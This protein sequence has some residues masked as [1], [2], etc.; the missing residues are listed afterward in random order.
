MV[1]EVLLEPSTFEVVLAAC[2]FA[3]VT[4]PA[5]ISH[6]VPVFETDMSPLSPSSSAAP[7]P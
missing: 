5:S 6:V 4:A 2:I 7:D 3:Y 1:V